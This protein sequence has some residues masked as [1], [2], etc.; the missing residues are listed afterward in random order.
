MKDHGTIWN[1]DTGQ[2]QCSTC[3]IQDLHQEL[4]VLRERLALTTP[5]GY[6]KMPHDPKMVDTV[7]LHSSLLRAAS[8]LHHWMEEHGVKDWELGSVASRDLLN[9]TQEELRET[10]QTLDR[11]VKYLLRA[12]E[13]ERASKSKATHGIGC[14]MLN[15]V[16]LCGLSDYRYA[17][18][19]AKVYNDKENKE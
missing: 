19:L 10:K 17:G 15:N 9:R 13:D 2:F 1:G 4:K 8:E 6:V 11:I 3:V 12:K 7:L 5:G 14:D 18:L 16:C